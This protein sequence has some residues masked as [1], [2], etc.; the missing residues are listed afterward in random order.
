MSRIEDISKYSPG[1]QTYIRI[2][3]EYKDCIL[4]YRLGDFYELFFEDAIECSKV[5]DLTLTGKN[6]G[7]AD[8]RAPMCGVP[9]HSCENYIKKLVDLGYKVAICE[10]MPADSRKQIPREVVQVITAGTVTMDSLL[11]ERKNNYILCVYK[12]NNALYACYSDITTGKFAI[13][14][15]QNNLEQS[16]ADLLSVVCPSEVIGNSEAKL[17]YQSLPLNNIRLLPKFYELLVSSFNESIC[18]GLLKKQFGENFKNVYSIKDDNEVLVMGALLSYLEQTQKRS[19]SNINRIEKDEKKYLFLD[20]NTR[21]N[22]ELVETVKEHKKYGSLLW[23]LDKTCTSMGARLFRTYFDKPL[24]N[25]SEIN[26]RLSAVEEIYKNIIL[27][28]NLKDVLSQIFDIERLAGK[29]AYGN[30]MPKELLSLKSS[31]EKLKTLKSVIKPCKSKLISSV[32]NEIDDFTDLCKVIDNAFVCPAPLIIREGGFIKSGFNEN[33]DEL[34]NPKL[35]AEQWVKEL[36]VSEQKQTGIKNLVISSNKIIGYYIEVSKSQAS[37]VPFDYKR[38]QTIANNERYVNED[39]IK[40]NNMVSMN[41]ESAIQ[42]ELQLFEEIKKY[43]SNFIEKIQNTA[44]AV[45]KLDTYLSLAISAQKYN[46]VRPTIT[47]GDTLEIQEGRHPIV[48]AFLRDVSFIPNDTHLNTTDSCMAIITGPNM[49]GKSTYMRQV[50]LISFMAH[51]GSFVPAQSATIPLLDRIFTRV[52]ASDDLAFGQS[53][54]MV[55]MSEVANILANATKKSLIILDEIGRGTST[56]DGLAIAYSVVEYLSNN[57]NAKTLFAT[58]YHELSELEG[59]VKGVK[60]YKVTVREREDKIIFLRKIERGQ[61]NR[62]F[63]VEV[64]E[65]AGVPKQVILRAK[66][67]SKNLEQTNVKLEVGKLIEPNESVKIEYE[68]KK[69]QSIVNELKDLDMNK[70]SP[71]SAFEILNELCQTAKKEL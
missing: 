22:L 37:L 31:L 44:M 67:I 3:E 64:A 23:L 32:Y 57:V 71:I 38:I 63:G 36:E 52:G 61:C 70:I 60:T 29:I 25:V 10:Q 66:E 55:E 43:A 33:L 2:K 56:F 42:L 35:K 34:R 7:L 11:D 20:S 26:D 58:H 41:E 5:L 39:L 45:A 19:L 9:F 53:T 27:K 4:F 59:I 65:L 8:E 62:S 13:K 14:S 48:E 28:D 51:M 18:T 46:Y 54:F 69:A 6:C 47:N 50:A 15:Y 1:F 21:R 68:Q 12:N 16:L 24:S 49:A 17:L 40:I 30:V